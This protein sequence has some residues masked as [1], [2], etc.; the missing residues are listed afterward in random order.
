M[1]VVAAMALAC[2]AGEGEVSE[3]SS[4]GVSEGSSAGVSAG[5]TSTGEPTGGGDGDG[6]TTGVTGITGITGTDSSGSDDS[7]TGEVELDA[8]LADCLRV[9]ACEAEGGAPVGVQACLAHALAVPWS[10]A[11][12][13]PQRMA[14]AVM[15]CKLAASDCAAVR[16]CTPAVDGFAAACEG[17]PG[18]DV[19][20]GD[21]WVVCDELG[22]PA[23]AMGCAAA[24]QTCMRDIWAGCA[25]E[26]CKFG[27][28]EPACEGDTLIECSPAGA[29]RRVDCPTQYNLA[30]VSG[31]GG[32][33]VF[34]V[35]GET[36][37]YDEQRGSLGCVGTGAPCE[38]FSQRCDGDVLE[39]CAGG[40]L[41]RRDCAGAL[42]SG[43]G[44]GFV[45]GGAFAGAASCGLIS[46]A[47]DLGADETCADGRIGFC[48]WDRPGTVDCRA[49]GY[50]GC[51]EAPLGDRTVAFCTP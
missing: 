6:G 22:A 37:G 51:A 13:G 48:D 23:M 2:G 14:L 41:A 7:E 45:Q 19:C 40:K 1:L 49:H 18:S 17:A 35:A 33:Q 12:V 11:T 4:T 39:T 27:E 50:G 36:C 10:W 25:E 26:P 31:K 47:C 29:L 24:G 43:Q 28:T 46:A 16:A 44:C 38:F 32:E 5:G 34:A 20:E 30:R 21:A 3:G 9:N 15:A 8:R 42:P